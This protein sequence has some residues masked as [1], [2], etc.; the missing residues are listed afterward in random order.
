MELWAICA[1]FLNV[2][3]VSDLSSPEL[4]MTASCF[5]HKFS[6]SLL[7]NIDH[8]F[9]QKVYLKIQFMIHSI[10]DFRIKFYLEKHL[11][12]NVDQ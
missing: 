5:F 12:F 8:S 7:R 1:K 6:L 3:K 2:C 11:V 9:I 10:Y 4:S